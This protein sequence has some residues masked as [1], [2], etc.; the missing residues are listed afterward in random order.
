MREKEKYL[1]GGLQMATVIM[2]STHVHCCIAMA[3]MNF[4]LLVFQA[5]KKY[6]DVGAD[7]VGAAM[8]WEALG[9]RRAVSS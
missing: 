9:K 7:A 2:V 4:M 8:S 6:N 3:T 5:L 1:C